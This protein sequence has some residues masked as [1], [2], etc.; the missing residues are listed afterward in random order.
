MR[1]SWAFHARGVGRAHRESTGGAPGVHQRTRN[2]ASVGARRAR[3]ARPNGHDVIDATFRARAPEVPVPRPSVRRPSPPRSL[4]EPRGAPRSMFR[5]HS[6][7][8]AQLMFREGDAMR[9]TGSAAARLAGHPAWRADAS[10]LSARRPSTPRPAPRP[11]STDP[12]DSPGGSSGGRSPMLF[13]AL[14]FGLPLALI[15]LLE[16]LRS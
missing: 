5:A 3:V 7:F 4:P 9:P 12:S 14:A 15:I 2:E 16:I 13:A 8:R 1:G 10:V 11:N 6:M